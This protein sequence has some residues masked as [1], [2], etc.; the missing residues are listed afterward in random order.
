MISAQLSLPGLEAH[1]SQSRNAVG[2][3]GE[4]TVGLALQRSGY[5]VDPNHI[6]GDLTVYLDKP[7][8]IEV[9]TARVNSDGLYKF[10]LYKKGCTNHRDA[11]I[12]VFLCIS[13]SGFGVPFVVPV[14]AIYFQST[15]EISNPRTYVGKLAKYKQSIKSMRL[16]SAIKE[17]FE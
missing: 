13:K 9:K 8:Y 2:A 12:V 4:M 5:R 6:R 10:S 16:E 17:L 3:A 15:A 14:S 11:D 7:L 1:M